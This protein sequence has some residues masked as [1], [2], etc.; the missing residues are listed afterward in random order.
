M[1]ELLEL[2]GV[3]RSERRGVRRLRLLV[4]VSLAVTAGQIVAVVGSR[5]EGKTALLKI[6]AGLE[7]PDAGE[8]WFRGRELTGM[9]ARA[10]ERLLGCE[11]AWVHRA[12]TGLP[13]DVLE[14]VT[15]PLLM[16]R[17]RAHDAEDQAMAALERVGAREAAHLRWEEL[18]DWERVLVALARGIVGRPRLLVMDEVIDGLGM[19]KTSDAGEL[20]CALVAELECGVLLGVSDPEAALMADRVWS[21]ERGSLRLLAGRTPVPDNVVEFP[22]DGAVSPGEGFGTGG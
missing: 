12:G 22:S 14:Y 19:S 3:Q 2:S 10:R 17:V 13:F 16:G 21:F 7:Q 6:A 5:Y 15:L 20:L 18:S 9:R 8:V 4:D 11:I 1:V